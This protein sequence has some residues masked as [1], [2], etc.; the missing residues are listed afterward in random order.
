MRR[1][2]RVVAG[3]RVVV[4][5]VKGGGLLLLLLFVD[6]VVGR[7][8]VDVAQ[9]AVVARD[10][11]V[12]ALDLLVDGKLGGGRCC[13]GEGLEVL[14]GWVGDVREVRGEGVVRG[15]WTL[16]DLHRG[17]LGTGS[18]VDGGIGHGRS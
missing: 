14:L 17:L 1:Q 8:D 6:G 9:V 3:C 11:A 13:W 15:G 18:A 7:V 10:V 12:V 4:M 16:V 5:F 2:V